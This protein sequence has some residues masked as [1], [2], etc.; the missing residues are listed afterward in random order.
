MKKK[1]NILD[2]VIVIALIIVVAAGAFFVNAIRNKPEGET[3]FIT[4]EVRETKDFYKDIIKVGD[5]A[6]DGVQNTKLGEVREF[7]VGP[8]MTD[9]ISTLTGEVERTEI[10]DRYDILLKIEV[11]AETEVQV[12]KQMWI[13]TALYKCDGFILEVSKE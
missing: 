6:Y 11:P 7:K 10:P 12:G 5:I 2:I 1:I 3:K 9:G 4:V 8:A 13:E